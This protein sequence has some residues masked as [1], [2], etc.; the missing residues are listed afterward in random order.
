[1]ANFFSQ[2]RRSRLRVYDLGRIIKRFYQFQSIGNDL[3]EFL[4]AGFES[5]QAF[6]SVALVAARE[7]DDY[8]V[9]RTTP[10]RALLFQYFDGLLYF[11]SEERRVGKEGTSWCE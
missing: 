8:I 11:R 7:A 10:F 4:V 5:H 2:L 9:Q 6:F 3:R 1:M